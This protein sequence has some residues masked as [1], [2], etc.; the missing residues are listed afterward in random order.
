MNKTSENYQ[1]LKK[2]KETDDLDQKKIN[3]QLAKDIKKI[4]EENKILKSEKDDL[5]ISLKN[6][7][8]PNKYD[9]PCNKRYVGNYFRN[10]S[11][12]QHSII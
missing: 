9:S 3:D 6:L 7:K 8:F 5:S 2:I 11:E 1:E 12:V 10:Y 4:V